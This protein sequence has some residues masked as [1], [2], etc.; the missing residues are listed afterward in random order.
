MKRLCLLALAL[1]L[2]SALF[3]E[4]ISFG[5]RLV[6]PY[7]MVDKDGAYSGIEYD[8][9]VAALAAKGY[10]VKP[11][12]YPLAR[13]V[14]TITTK[15][16]QGAAPILPS[17]NTGAALSDSYISY[18]NVALA[19]K[20]RGL[21]IKTVADLKGLPVMAF[22]TAKNVLGP[23]FAAAMEGN[24]KYV[25][26]GQQVLQI[27]SL[28]GGRTDVVIGESRILAWYIKAPETD[29]DATTPVQEFRIFPP[30][31]Y[32]AAFIDPKV[33]AA[34]NEGLK[35]IKANGSYDKIIAKYTK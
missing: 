5:F 17:H 21:A 14:N 15:G 20:K 34:F 1:L 3:A 32:C 19:L 27:R 6:P 18:N 25:E 31:N 33:A 30:T 7:V 11:S 9:I 13:L 2:A 24:A 12:N 16:I 8:I 22:Q 26:E 29:V 28:F 4:D 23:D 10:T 35:A